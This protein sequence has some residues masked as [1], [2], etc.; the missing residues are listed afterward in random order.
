MT[1]SRMLLAALAAV[2]ALALVVVVITIAR[3]HIPPRHETDRSEPAQRDAP[4]L[5]TATPHGPPAEDDTTAWREPPPEPNVFGIV[6]D[7][8]GEPVEGALV[9]ACHVAPYLGTPLNTEGLE[10]RYDFGPKIDPR[11]DPTAAECYAGKGGFAWG[12]PEDRGFA[13]GGFPGA[14]QQD[15]RVGPPWGKRPQCST[16][17]NGRFALRVCDK[18]WYGLVVMKEG[19]YSAVRIFHEPQEGIRL[20]L[21]GPGSIIGRVI[22]AD[23]GEPVTRFTATLTWETYPASDPREKAIALNDDRGGFRFGTAPSRACWLDVEADGYAPVTRMVEPV[24]G[25]SVRLVV[26]LFRSA[27]LTGRVV[28]ESSGEPVPEAF[29]VVEGRRIRGLGACLP[30]DAPYGAVDEAGAFSI[31]QVPA[32]PARVAVTRLWH[33]PVSDYMPL[34]EQE[35]VLLPGQTT[36]VVLRVPD[37]KGNVSGRVITSEGGAPVGDVQVSLHPPFLQPGGAFDERPD[38]PIATTTDSSGAFSFPE[39]PSGAY[40]LG[41]QHEDYVVADEHAI[42]VK[43]GESVEDVVVELARPARVEGRV[44]D[45]SGRPVRVLVTCEAALDVGANTDEAGDYSFEKVTPGHTI[46]SC[47]SVESRNVLTSRFVDVPPGETVH[48][49]FV[50]PRTYTVSGR[51]TIAGTAL[52]GGLYELLPVPGQTDP[53]TNLAARGGWKEDGGRFRF[54]NV[55]PGKYTLYGR[56]NVSTQGMLAASMPVEVVADDAELELELPAGMITGRV[57]DR[58]SGEP[59][60]FAMVSVRREQNLEDPTKGRA[61]VEVL[62]SVWADAHTG[63]FTFGPLGDG[64]YTITA[65]ED[66]YGLEHTEVDVVDAKMTGDADIRLSAGYEVRCTLASVGPHVPVNDALIAVRDATGMLVAE[67]HI[68][69]GVGDPLSEHD[70]CVMEYLPPGDYVFEAVSPSTAWHSVELTV[71]EHGKNLVE[72]RLPAGKALV[73]EVA[74]AAGNPVLGAIPEIKDTLGRSR[75]WRTGYCE[76]DWGLALR[77]ASDGKGLTRIEHLL[78][79]TYTLTVRAA[80]YGSVEQQVEGLDADETRVKVILDRVEDE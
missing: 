26:R 67:T 69:A 21:Y 75:L 27:G 63:S 77:S 70:E 40:Q 19:Y 1:R 22:D 65:S 53:T 73:V 64:R 60:P 13:S 41:L 57:L 24:M 76:Q 10:D 29:V 49:N 74:D 62:D 71:T 47:E 11:D 36:N 66:G 20:V 48:A 32:G 38:K 39:V 56:F 68:R 79:G 59:V 61:D 18:L 25:V 3:S 72:F 8:E 80:G 58:D 12:D 9:S 23:T 5:T 51:A 14:G 2:C 33:G 54:E 45:T 16:G 44:T 46:L 52:D 15:A 6:V 4:G 7:E 35:L 34:V 31:P 30:G 55:P 43:P 28:W 37:Q 50:L 78:P 42:R 17:E